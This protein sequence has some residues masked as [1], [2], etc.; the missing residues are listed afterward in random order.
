MTIASECEPEECDGEEPD[1]YEGDEESC[2]G[3]VGTVLLSVAGVE[4]CLYWDKSEHY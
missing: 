1:G 2:F 3:A 4:P